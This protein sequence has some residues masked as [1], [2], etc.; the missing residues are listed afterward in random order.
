LARESGSGVHQ[1]IAL[2]AQ[3]SNAHE[4]RLIPDQGHLAASE[5]IRQFYERDSHTPE[6]ASEEQ[7]FSLDTGRTRGDKQAFLR[8]ANEGIAAMPALYGDKGF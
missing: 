4:Q 5:F 6:S 3:T 2:S 1:Q 8:S 7:E